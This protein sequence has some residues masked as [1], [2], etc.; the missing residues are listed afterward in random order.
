MFGVYNYE[1]SLEKILDTNIARTIKFFRPSSLT[2]NLLPSIAEL[3]LQMEEKTV[4]SKFNL[5]FNSTL[6]SYSYELICHD[7][8]INL[9]PALTK[10]L[11][12]QRVQWE[13][14]PGITDKALPPSGLETYCSG[15]NGKWVPYGKLRRGIYAD[16]DRYIAV[17]DVAHTHVGTDNILMRRFY[18]GRYANEEAAMAEYEKERTLRIVNNAYKLEVPRVELP[19]VPIT[20]NPTSIDQTSSNPTSSNSTSSNPTSSNPTSSNP[21]SSNP[22]SSNPPN[23]NPNPNPSG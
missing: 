20:A 9:Y 16:R 21:T 12:R 8:S 4:T 13:N 15:N 22:T 6:N 19:P 17:G 18:L 23:P 14:L 5:S 3:K 7:S 1:E 10:M 2:H 11:K